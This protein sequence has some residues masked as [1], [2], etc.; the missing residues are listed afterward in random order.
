VRPGPR[1]G[2]N[3]MVRNR[4]GQCRRR[5][6]R[7]LRQLVPPALRASLRHD[8]GLESMKAIKKTK[9][10]PTGTVFEPASEAI[11]PRKSPAKSATASPAGKPIMS[12]LR[13]DRCI[14]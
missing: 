6:M 10:P 8:I 2:H 1:S 11:R 7:C 5:R 14:P 4:L 12:A 13:A 9:N 3:A